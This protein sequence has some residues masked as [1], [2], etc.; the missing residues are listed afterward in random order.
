MD[1]TY[2]LLIAGIFLVLLGAA[3]LV[4]FVAQFAKLIIGLVILVLGLYLVGFS[5]QAK[6]RVR[7]R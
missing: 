1:K 4:E 6:P 7:V 2:V 5:R 3:M